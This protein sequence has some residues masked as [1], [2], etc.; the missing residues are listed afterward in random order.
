MRAWPDP[1]IEVDAVIVGAGIAG[2]ACA[3]FLAQP[4][5]RVVLIDRRPLH[6]AG[7][8]WING[9]PAWAFPFCGLRVPEPPERRFEGAT[10]VLATPSR[11]HQLRT[12]TPDVWA[13]DMRLLGERLRRL[14]VSWG[15]I[16]CGETRVQ[17]LDRRS[18]HGWQVTT[19]SGTF[20]TPLLIDASGVR[21]VLRQHVMT[22]VRQPG[23][24]DLCSAAQA[25]YAIR[26]TA[27][28][29]A[30]MDRYGLRR[31]E[32][33]AFRGI[34]GGYSIVN[35]SVDPEA[36]D[37]SLLTGTVPDRAGVPSGMRLLQAF[38]AEQPWIGP[39]QFGGA[40]AIPIRRPFSRL[41]APG[42]ALV[43]DA[44]CQVFPAHGSGIAMGLCAA[45]MLADAVLAAPAGAGGDLDVLW[46]YAHRFHS[47]FGG[48]LCSYDVLRR[49][50]Q[51]F[52]PEDTERLVESGLL[53]SASV[54]ASLQ[55]TMPD[56]D[57]DLLVRAVQGAAR[58]GTLALPLALA[59]SRMPAVAWWA[60]RY[61]RR[62]DE[63]RLVAYE[64]GLVR[65]MG[66]RP[67][68]A[69]PVTPRAG[70]LAVLLR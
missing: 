62:P 7:P 46:A 32:A 63:R 50:V 69:G 25:V 9:V 28:A 27:G 70:E 12:A 10:L 60:R 29:E 52:R 67:D 24:A 30:F 4:G 1:A 43:G 11:R 54:S 16:M 13:V 33:L 55:Q 31:G 64:R 37:L 19:T 47:T 14:A 35:V 45:R 40:G 66:V 49:A 48:L 38:L 22:D 6:E 2:T 58:A 23:P 65:L 68:M 21:A 39:R 5:R 42:F 26:D 57:G 53:S 41:V 59:A 8:R 61:P 51:R 34:A 3:G 17:R 20:R 15:V 56:W 36:G 18:G 44:A